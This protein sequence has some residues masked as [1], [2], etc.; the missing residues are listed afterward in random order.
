MYGAS[1]EKA[2]GDFRLLNMTFEELYQELEENNYKT[3]SK[4]TKATLKTSVV[5]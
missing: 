4:K 5:S 1:Q 3:L 2:G